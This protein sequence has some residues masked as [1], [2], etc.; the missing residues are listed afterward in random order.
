MFTTIQD[1]NGKVLGRIQDT[2]TG[3]RISTVNGQPLGTYNRDMN[4]TSDMNGHVISNQNTL[5]SLIRG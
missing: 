5:A 4:R 3:Q 2:P 1:R